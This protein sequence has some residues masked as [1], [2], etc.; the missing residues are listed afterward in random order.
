MLSVLMLVGAAVLIPFSRGVAQE[1][2][3]PV[4]ESCKDRGVSVCRL[5]A[6]KA[7]ESELPFES[8][9]VAQDC[10]DCG[11]VRLRDCT[12]CEHAAEIDV[13]AA[14]TTLELW[15]NT[16][17]PIDEYM[18]T[19]DLVHIESAHF[20]VTS[21]VRKTDAKRATSQ[22]AA[23]HWLLDGLERQRADFCAEAGCKDEDFG[24]KLHVMLW[25]KESDQSKA[26]SRYTLERAN[27]QAKLMGAKPVI[28]LLC[29][30]GRLRTD[31]DLR[32]ALVHQAAHCLLSSVF[33]PVALM[34]DK[35]GWIDEGL[36]HYFEIKYFGEAV[37]WCNVDPKVL[38]AAKLG[39]F[40]AHV[41]DGLAHAAV[42]SLSN[43][44]G[45]DLLGLAPLQRVFAWSY[46]DCL[47]RK[48][49]GTLARLAK[50]LKKRKLVT[51]ALQ[52][53]LDLPQADFE[54]AW[55]D[56]VKASYTL[57]PVRK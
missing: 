42:P 12:M 41:L 29:G 15:R 25:I 55:H 17:R 16:L 50:Q 33:E 38:E 7:C 31:V 40:E 37:E 5:C 51:E 30:K 28:S 43:V 20:I 27:A 39:R 53:A 52:L 9:S 6:S 14:R 46:V 11:G 57:K 44:A 19:K 35:S 2:P 48:Y 49:P 3:R 32:H 45:S 23:A 56:F 26:A 24:G 47:M 1:P 8:C 18:N 4:C 36:A 54:A 21:D 22:H 34:N 10:G 13:A